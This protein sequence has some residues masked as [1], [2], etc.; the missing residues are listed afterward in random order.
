MNTIS[1]L[2]ENINLFF[3][4]SNCFLKKIPDKAKDIMTAMNTVLLTTINNINNTKLSTNY[5]W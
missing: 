3:L 2:F 5:Y 1:K 4:K